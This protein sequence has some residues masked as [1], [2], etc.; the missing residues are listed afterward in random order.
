[1]V[2]FILSTHGLFISAIV[3]FIVYLQ[4]KIYRSNSREMQVLKNVFP[5]NEK[6]DSGIREIENDYQRKNEEI[7]NA[8]DYQLEEL[9][10]KNDF[11]IDDFYKPTTIY[12]HLGKLETHKIFKRL[13]AQNDLK[14][15]AQKEKEK[16]IENLHITYRNSQ[17]SIFTT[18]E[19]SIQK[20]VEA[21]KDNISDFHLMKDI[22]E[23]NCDAKEDEIERQIPVPLYWG[24][25]GT[26]LGIL[27]GVG[28]L[29]FS[30][31]LSALLNSDMPKSFIDNFKANNPH[32]AGEEL[33]KEMKLVWSAKG[34]EG[35]I[36]LM[37]GV[38]LAMIASFCGIILTTKAS[39]KFKTV[40]NIL[41]SKKHK[42]LSKIQTELLPTLSS[43]VSSSLVKMSQNLQKFNSEF[44]KN[45]T[46][47][48][49]VLRTVNDASSNVTR[50]LTAI[51]NLNMTK[52]AQANI[53]VY[54]KLKNCT[55]EIGKLGEYLQNINQYQ[56]NTTEA[57]EKMNHFF[58]R[59]INEIDSIDGKVREALECFG[60]KTEGYL[61][62][63]QIQ[64]DSQIGNIEDAL[65]QQQ[66][67][68]SKHLEV[69][70]AQMKTAI[71]EQQEIFK[72]KMNETT[73]FVEQLNKIGDKIAS[74]SR[75]EKAMNEQNGNLNRLADKID[76]LANSKSSGTA[77]QIQQKT[78]IWQITLIGIIA[79]SCT[80]I[81]VNSFIKP[82]TKIEKPEMIESQPIIKQPV[83][84]EIKETTSVTDSLASNNINQTK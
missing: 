7:E 18:I 31:A 43:D 37:S 51:Q 78:P 2:D 22:V 63:L 32:L 60:G 44:S 23:R 6:L 68:L 27:I 71:N 4:F 75:L 5:D 12:N 3:L 52:I 41:E 42:Y 49:T 21:N 34:S 35:V 15:I 82:K 57:I 48:S 73:L 29:V 54:E 10:C 67:A 25:A 79:L 65:K 58:K 13:N 45:T 64:L 50:T 61:K 9:L 53:E 26:M 72:Q 40:K 76:K 28:F 62:N 70:S 47:F 38:A 55:D 84:P 59:G 80:V 11:S 56:A 8:S 46:D 1:M 39:L 77:V 16:A 20:Y 30:D 66:E 69:V 19:N 24:L 36:A 81:A 74:I 14:K 83:V 17:S 33:I